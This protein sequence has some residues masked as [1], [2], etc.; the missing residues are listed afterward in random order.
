MKTINLSLMA[1]ALLMLGFISCKKNDPITPQPAPKFSKTDSLKTSFNSNE[2]FTLYDFKNGM[3]VPNSDSATTKWDVGF[4]FVNLII[5]SH[6][7]G[8]GTA[9]VITQM[10]DASKNITFD[11]LNMAPESGY[12]YDTSATKRAINTDLTAGWYNYNDVT[13]VFSPKADRFFII[14]TSDNH[15]VKLE[16][17][18]VDYAEFVGY[19]PVTLIY[20]FRY[21]YQP[22][23]SRN[24]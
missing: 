14:K 11:G 9:G 24:F 16:I 8:P 17:L 12:A 21:T 10:V 22:D 18:K 6:S 15:Y 20:T 1:C 5:N 2:S 3:V 19:T 23:G 7:S 13:H 4:N